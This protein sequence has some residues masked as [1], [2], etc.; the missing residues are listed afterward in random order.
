MKVYEIIG[1]YLGRH[2]YPI[3]ARNRR[4][5]ELHLIKLHNQ[6]S[7]DEGKNDIATTY[8]E[9]SFCIANIMSRKEYENDS[10]FDE[11]YDNLQCIN[12]NGDST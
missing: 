8:K 3:K 4:S 2:S 7:I 9:S 6:A 11:E 10:Y 5:V 1:G 12:E